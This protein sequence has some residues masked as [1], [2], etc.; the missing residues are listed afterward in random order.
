[1]LDKKG[2]DM[3]EYPYKSYGLF[4]IRIEISKGNF[5]PFAG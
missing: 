5:C 3:L 1:M 4:C 2:R